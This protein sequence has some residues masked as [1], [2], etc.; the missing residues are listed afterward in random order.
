[1]RSVASRQDTVGLGMLAEASRANSILSNSIFPLSHD[2]SRR[3]SE[4]LD[5][6]ECPR[7]MLAEISGKPRIGRSGGPCLLS[8]R[9]VSYPVI[10]R[11]VNILIEI[12]DKPTFHSE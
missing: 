8:I 7:A 4:V 12:T 5:S 9:G 11:P 10:S 2:R 6:A 3:R 1:M